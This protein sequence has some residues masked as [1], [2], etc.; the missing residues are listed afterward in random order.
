MTGSN[1]AP[2][3]AKVPQLVDPQF[4]IIVDRYGAPAAV[5]GIVAQ[6]AEGGCFPVIGQDNSNLTPIPWQLD[7]GKL[8]PDNWRLADAKNNTITPVADP[9]TG[10]M[11]LPEKTKY[12]VPVPN[13]FNVLEV[14]NKPGGYNAVALYNP[15]TGVLIISNA[16][17]DSSHPIPGIKAALH[18][19]YPGRAA[20]AEEFL[21][22][23]LVKIRRSHNSKPTPLNERSLFL[24]PT[25]VYVGGHS[26]GGTLAAAQTYHL[27][28]LY[29]RDQ[30]LHKNG[31]Y[32]PNKHV[33]YSDLVTIGVDG[34]PK[35]VLVT[36]DSFGDHVGQDS[37]GLAVDALGNHIGPNGLPVQAGQQPL[38]YQQVI[39]SGH[40]GF[41][42]KSH[43]SATAQD[44]VSGLGFNIPSTQLDLQPIP[45]GPDYAIKTY[46]STI[47]STAAVSD[48]HDL[49]YLNASIFAITDAAAQTAQV[50]KNPHDKALASAKKHFENMEASGVKV[51]SHHS[52]SSASKHAG[53]VANHSP[54]NKTEI[55]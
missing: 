43:Q 22:N 9:K 12:A 42:E 15:T 2:N 24:E 11:S 28:N 10:V 32:G 37:T 25:K 44:I 33:P 4:N 3:L 48:K 52:H 16:G 54:K 35:T 46:S 19:E 53:Y 55:G 13:G 17:L 7:A 51:A 1:T 27:A 5:M 14:A 50:T 6:G 31:K 26:V 30:E 8:T 38:T 40:G 41:V 23:A 39:A 47:P 34:Q 49:Q 18:D 21:N 36:H 20:A 45:N 29:E